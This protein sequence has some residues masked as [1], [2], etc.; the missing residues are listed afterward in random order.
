MVEHNAEYNRLWDALRKEAT[1]LM[2]SWRG[3]IFLKIRDS[4]NQTALSLNSSIT[5][6]STPSITSIKGKPCSNELQFLLNVLTQ[7]NYITIDNWPSWVPVTASTPN[8]AI[9]GAI[10]LEPAPT[11]RVQFLS[12]EIQPLS[13]DAGHNIL[14]DEINRIFALSNFGTV[15][16]DADISETEK[17]RRRTDK[18]FKNDGYTSR[19][20]KG[21]KGVDRSPMFH[22][23]ISLKDGRISKGSENRFLEN[24]SNIQAVT[25]VLNAMITQW[26]SAH[27]F[28]P[29]DRHGKQDRPIS[30]ST[31]STISEIE[32]QNATL[33]P[34]SA[35]RLSQQTIPY[36]SLKSGVSKRPLSA[37]EIRKRARSTTSQSVTTSER[38]QHQSF[39]EWS[40][41]KSGKAG[42]FEKL[43][44]SGKQRRQA[45]LAQEQL[46]GC[47]PSSTNLTV[48]D[49]DPVFARALNTLPGGNNS[50]RQ[51]PH[52]GKNGQ[53]ST[54]NPY[55]DTIAWMDPTTK[56]ILILNAQTGSVMPK[57]TTR[58]DTNSSFQSLENITSR[59]GK[60]FRILPS[61]VVAEEG[62]NTWLKG[63][64]QNW[65]NPIFKPAENRIRQVSLKESQ[66][67]DMTHKHRGHS[68]CSKI[69]MDKAFNESSLSSGSNLSRTDLQNAQIIAQLDK[70][71]ILVKM[72][73]SSHREEV[74]MLVMI[75]QHAADERVRVEALFAELCAPLP[76]QHSHSQYHS[77]LGHKSLVAFTV[78]EKPL[79]FTI[80]TQEGEQFT[81]YASRFAAWGILYDI[82]T[83]LATMT[84][85][86]GAIKT[87]SMLLVA[88]LPPSISE[89]C[90]ASPQLLISLLR[91]TVWE[92][93]EDP[94][95][96]P[97]NSEPVPLANRDNES[98]LWS[99]RLATCPRGLVDFINSRA[100]RSAI[101]F[102]DE[103]STQQCVELVSKLSKCVFPFMCAHGRPSMVP[104]VDMGQTWSKGLGLGLQS[105]D[106]VRGDKGFVDAWKQWQKQ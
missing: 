1:A 33:S 41:I 97:L 31:S 86:P 81:R 51:S 40:R 84:S 50:S 11:R 53:G 13:S 19:Q 10:S 27:H 47:V 22:L 29:L 59:S 74:G 78:L 39:A 98:P 36:G 15:E 66:M 28:R 25:D 48:F 67:D 38:M 17:I 12:L 62:K 104:L 6:A 8:I 75:D 83:A 68:D 63:I 90:K 92:Y 72:V 18:R 102:N 52:L 76:K 32:R 88:T 26:L 103:L 61:S 2:L 49:S 54:E 7:S 34:G 91:T 45:F 5:P 56:Q 58:P 89:R 100:C 65:D 64:L 14:Y 105:D 79:Q 4:D 9:K 20:L 35:V 101:M 37:S 77:S 3:S 99:R 106:H 80:S 21:R 42:F 93:A 30:S 44:T 46:S 24:E 82:S 55:D 23:R 70:K 71:F 95:L 16:D 73:G 57:A 85:R 60:C 96:P 69:D 43:G 94:H 87:D